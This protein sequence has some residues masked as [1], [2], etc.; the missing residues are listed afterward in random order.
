VK[1]AIGVEYDGSPFSGWQRQR[2]APSV[3]AALETSLSQVAGAAL[4]LHC[5]GRTDAGVHAV[6]QVAHFESRAERSEKAWVMGGNSNLPDAVAVLWARPVAEDFHARY[7]AESRRYRYII[8]N[9]RQRPALLHGRVGWVYQ[10]LEAEP[11]QRAGQALIGEHDFSAFRAAGCQARHARRCVHAIDVRRDG[12]F[13]YLDIAAN[14]FLHNMVRIIA[15]TLI[16]VGRGDQ[17]LDWP[18]QLLAGR[19]RTAAAATAPPGGL[20]FVGP[21]YPAR[22]ALPAARHLPTF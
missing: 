21:G 1:I 8:D 22:F 4:T 7:S 5:A 16:A 19:D 20:Y 12:D 10:P 18:A 9:R 17:P 15:G 6:Q 2:H 11:M 3:Q 13:V 14:A